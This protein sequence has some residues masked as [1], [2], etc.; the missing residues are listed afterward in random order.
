MAN[1]SRF[2]MEN[3]ITMARIKKGE[4]VCEGGGGG[5]VTEDVSAKN[6][7]KKFIFRRF[8]SDVSLW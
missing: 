5:V 6:F 8:H 3:K 1:I 2:I 7:F 4:C